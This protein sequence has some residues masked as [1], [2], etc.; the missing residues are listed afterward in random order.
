MKT[1]EQIIASMCLTYRH[2]YGLLK[3][4]EDFIGSGMTKEEQEILWDKMAQI[5]DNDI[6]PNIKSV[7]ETYNIDFLNS[8]N[9]LLFPDIEFKHKK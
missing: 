8:Q 2:D 1:R 7:L 6:I 3:H 9:K 4:P 5:F